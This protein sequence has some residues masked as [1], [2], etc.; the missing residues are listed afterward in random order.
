MEGIEEQYRIL[1]KKLEDHDGYYR[2]NDGSWIV[3][4]SNGDRVAA[5]AFQGNAKRGQGWCSPDPVGQ[6]RAR[7][8]AAA[9]EMLEA[10][11]AVCEAYG[12]ECLDEEPKGHCPMCQGRL[13]ISH[14]T[15]AEKGGKG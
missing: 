14:A 3:T 1:S 8:I 12:C 5:V 10:L 11:I 4:D 7:L 15:G 2:E 6:S 9:P 13:A